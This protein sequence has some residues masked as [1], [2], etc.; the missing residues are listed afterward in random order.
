VDE[1]VLA[2]HAAHHGIDERYNQKLWMKS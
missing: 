1:S 2:D